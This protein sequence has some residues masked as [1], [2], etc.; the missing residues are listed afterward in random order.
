[1]AY[2]ARVHL[3]RRVLEELRVKY[4]RMLA[5]RLEHVSGEEDA[6]QVRGRMAELAT[7]FPGALR[8]LDDLD[9]DEIRRRVDA[10][11]RA[12]AGDEPERWI[13]AVAR[14]HALTR[15]ALCA[16]RWLGK[17]REIDASVQAAYLDATPRLEYPDD[18]HA[19]SADLRLIASPPRGRITHAVLARVAVELGTNEDEVRRMIFGMPRRMRRAI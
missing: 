15:G 4:A 18:A 19:W 7:R 14:F 5:M 13:A 1:M 11:E 3:G 2:I 6:D 8:E 12:L 9:L 17:R 10:L 16:K